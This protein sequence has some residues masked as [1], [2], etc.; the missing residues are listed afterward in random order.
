[1]I[2]KGLSHVHFLRAATEVER[3]GV[4]RSRAARHYD[5]L[6][7]GKKYPP[8]YIISLANRFAHGSVFPA[9]SFNAVEAKD[10]LLRHGYKV[11]DRRK[12]V[13]E[14]VV[15]QDDESTFPEGA[16]RF[17]IHRFLERDNGI[18][19]KAKKQ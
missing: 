13:K 3:R 18:T 12:R 1:M 8:K 4:P 9:G 10:Y 17:A 19:K 16:E 2:P 7:N 15:P 6:L 5:L 14:V 11:I